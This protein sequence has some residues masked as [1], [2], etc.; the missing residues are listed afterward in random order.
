MYG[1]TAQAVSG[2]LFKNIIAICVQFKYKYLMLNFIHSFPAFGSVHAA[3][4]VY[5]CVFVCLCAECMRV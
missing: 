5:V 4:C 2:N 1:F 3:A